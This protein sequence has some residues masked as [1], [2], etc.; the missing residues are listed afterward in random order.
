MLRKPSALA[1]PPG[2]ARTL[3]IAQLVT[4]TGNGAFA[5]CSA[6]YFTRVVGISP[7][8][9]G[10]GLSVAG[11]AGVLAGV[12]AGHLADSRG[13][14]NIAVVLVALTGLAS[15]GFIVLRSYAAFV[16]V[17]CCFALFDRGGYAARQAMI[18]TVLSGTSLLRARA[19]LRVVTNVGMSL[20]AGLGAIALAADTPAAYRGVLAVD[21]V[22]F[23]GCALMLLRLPATAPTARR[24]AAGGPRLVVLRDRPYAT[25]ALIN[26]VLSM[27]A[28]LLD[29]VLPLWIVRHTGVPRPMIAALVVLNTVTV[30]VAQVRVTKGIDGLTPAVRAMRGAGLLLLGACVL[31]ATAAGTPVLLAAALLVGGAML[32]VYAEM[33]QSAASWVLAYELA[34]AERRGQYQ[35]LFDTGLAANQVIAPTLLTVLV[36]SG[37]APGWVVL[38]CLF[39]VAGWAISP[40]T[41]WARRTRPVP[42]TS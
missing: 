35:A 40:A 36:I 13:A 11:I 14:R 31:F 18:A 1:G 4:T 20:G 10:L 32:H 30:V 7:T 28:P 16:V 9:F 3:I 33:V 5:T 24:D 27:H 21:A 29:V 17:A 34:P 23:I 6:L 37:G 39:V 41:R 8:A 15:V 38:G 26:M 19:R 42:A 12:P 2:P 25:T 22:S